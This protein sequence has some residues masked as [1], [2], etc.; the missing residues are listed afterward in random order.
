MTSELFQHFIKSKIKCFS[1]KNPDSKLLSETLF[2][3]NL[4]L[5]QLLNLQTPEVKRSIWMFLHVLY[6]F[7][8][9][10]L[11]LPNDNYRQEEIDKLY[12]VLNIM[13]HTSPE[14]D[15]TDASNKIYNL[16]NVEVN[17]ET[18]GMIDDI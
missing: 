9:L 4:S 14:Y 17:D 6:L 18:K 8:Q 2:G 10:S 11:V 16:L 12:S 13:P 3:P 1:H 7:S 15:K 5:K